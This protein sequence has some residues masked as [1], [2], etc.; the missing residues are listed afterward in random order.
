MSIADSGGTLV[1][2]PACVPAKFSLLSAIEVED[3]TEAD[4]H[5]QAGYSWDQDSCEDLVVV[6]AC[7]PALEDK[8]ASLEGVETFFGDPFTM[9]AGYTCS[10]GGRR[11]EQAW[12]FAQRRL[13][14]SENRTAERT[15]WTGTDLGDNPVRGTLRHPFDDPDD[16]AVDV[17]PVAGTAVDI[18]TGLALLEDFM[19]DCYPCSPLIHASRGTAVHMANKGLLWDTG[20]VLL[21]LG[22]GTRVIPGGGYLTSG[23]DGSAADPGT[24]WIFATGALKVLRS[25]AFFTPPEGDTAAAINRQINDIEVFAE[26]TYGFIHDCCVAAVLVETT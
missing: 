17:T 19:G 24:A 8:S 16:L 9:V 25:P 12:E 13:E 15:F 7:P 6:Q 20:Q 5:W 2:P 10:T 11:L 23:P 18:A 4:G 21:S 3:R 26:R 14:R 1:T 22:T